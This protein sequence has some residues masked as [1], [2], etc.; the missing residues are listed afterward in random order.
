MAHKKKVGTSGRYGSRYGRKVRFKVRTVEALKNSK[1]ECP[2]CGKTKI[3]RLS[4]GIYECRACGS[5]IAGK[6]YTLE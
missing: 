5:K 3:K 1:Q 2:N 4:Q 6:A